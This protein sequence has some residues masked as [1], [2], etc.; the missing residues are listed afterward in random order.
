MKQ[1]STL[2]AGMDGRPLNEMLD[3]ILVGFL[4][5]GVE[6]DVAVL[7]LR[8]A[9]LQNESLMLLLPAEPESLAHVRV[10]VREW[11]KGAAL[12]SEA[13]PDVITAVGEAAS[14]VVTHAYGIAKGEMEIEGRRTPTELVITVRDFGRWRESASGSGWGTR[15]M[16]A[17][18]D[19]VEVD[20]P[21]TG[22][23]IRLRKRLQAAPVS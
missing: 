3:N 9:P 6:D 11:L 20:T 13:V 14:N 2:A 4:N 10:A 19:S 21:E 23:V 5:G 7:G 17:L 18:V 22:T 16:R 15:L 1:L 8:L 12:P